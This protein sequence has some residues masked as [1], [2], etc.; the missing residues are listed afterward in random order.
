MQRSRVHRVGALV[1]GLTLV[2][3]ACGGDDDDASSTDAPAATDAAGASECGTA[4]S[5]TTD[6]A[7]NGFAATNPAGQISDDF[8]ERVCAVDPALED[9]NYAAEAYDAAVVIALATEIAGDDGIAFASEINGVTRDGEKCTNFAECNELVAAGTDI[10]YDGESGPIQMAGNGEPLEASYGLFKLGDDNRVDQSATEYIPVTGPPELDVPEVPV[11]GDRAGDGTL[12]IGTLLPQ[13]GNLSYLG[14]PEF[15]GFDLALQE[16]NEAGGVLGKD[17]V[18]IKGDS[19]DNDTTGDIANP[20]VDR[21][22]SE[23]VDAII[24]AASSGVS[25]KVIDKVTG[26]GVV[27]FS[28]ANTSTELSDYPDEGLYFRTAPPDIYQGQVL[29]QFIIDD[30]N[31]TVAILNRNDSYGNSLAEQVAATVTESG[32]EV[33]VQTAYD[34]NATSFDS[35][36]DAIVAADPDAIV[37]I[38]FDESSK[39]LR[40]MVEKGIGPLDK[41]VYG[42]DGNAGNATGQNFDAGN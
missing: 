17:V 6:G 11:E 28:A 22:I 35:E 3:A 29:G 24:G 18:G 26:A 23:N 27:L 2:A 37:V 40:S 30:G 31:Q 16:I 12:T 34:G 15:A 7:L 38:G 19:G 1:L 32:G 42:C 41:M 10:D 4:P 39:I 14:P 33:V 9:F 25:L 5:D 20:T 13:T 21:L 36:V 8:I